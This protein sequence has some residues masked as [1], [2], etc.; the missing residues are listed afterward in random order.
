MGE[1]QWCDVINVTPIALV[2][3]WPDGAVKNWSRSI[4]DIV[5]KE[6]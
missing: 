6:S 4:L 2:V 3:R 1:D 5:V